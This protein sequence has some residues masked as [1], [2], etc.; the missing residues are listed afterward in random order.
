MKFLRLTSYANITSASTSRNVCYGYLF[1]EAQ[2]SDLI[3][4]RLKMKR[5]VSQ[6]SKANGPKWRQTRECRR[7]KGREG[8]L[9]KARGEERSELGNLLSGI[10]SFHSSSN[11]DAINGEYRQ[12]NLALRCSVRMARS[13]QSITIDNDRVTSET[14]T[15]REALFLVCIGTI[16]LCRRRDFH[17]CACAR[18]RS[19]CISQL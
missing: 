8:A 10:Q 12:H 19:R 9:R 5:H 18:A 13:S 4:P 16:P 11:A 14:E 17:F 15:L 2:S 7:E 1:A 6:E 3:R